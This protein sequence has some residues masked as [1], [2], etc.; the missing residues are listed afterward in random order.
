MRSIPFCKSCE[1]ALVES[2]LLRLSTIKFTL[3]NS[4]TQIPLSC[5]SRLIQKLCSSPDINDVNII[6]CEILNMKVT[7]K[8]EK[9]TNEIIQSFIQVFKSP[10]QKGPYQPQSFHDSFL[11]FPRKTTQ[12]DLLYFPT[13]IILYTVFCI[14]QGKLPSTISC[15]L[16][17]KSSQIKFLVFSKENHFV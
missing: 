11:Y 14:S 7:I 9:T 12:Y 17:G 15:I 10:H 1:E 6:M 13:K 4:S 5:A 2:D 3:K 16:R 8:F